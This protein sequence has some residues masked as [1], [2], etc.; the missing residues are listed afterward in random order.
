MAKPLSNIVIAMV[1]LNDITWQRKKEIEDNFHEFMIESRNQDNIELIEN[2]LAMFNNCQI[3]PKY[4]N[5]AISTNDYFVNYEFV[6]LRNQILKSLKSVREITINVNEE[7]NKDEYVAMV[8]LHPILLKMT[9][10]VDVRD[11]GPYKIFKITNDGIL[12]NI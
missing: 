9:Y 3:N 2:F 5:I 10:H 12:D 1:N 8:Q 6:K 11:S 7:S 4:T